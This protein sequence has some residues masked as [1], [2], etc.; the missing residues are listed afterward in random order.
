MK[1]LLLVTSLFILPLSTGCQDSP[2]SRKANQEAQ[3]E[4]NEATRA[5]GDAV[6]VQKREYRK[7]M[8]SELERIDS[9]MKVWKVKMQD[10]TGDAKA[11]MQE[12]LDQL[13][14]KRKK[15]AERLEDTAEDSKAAWA[16]VKQGLD[17]AFNELSDA[18][19]K[20]KEQFK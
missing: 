5:T 8:E 4:I 16:D 18:F 10:A 2:E 20:A 6:A 15:A 13:E 11:S 17:R 12:R 3:R 7:K 1:Q 14:V 9:Q 19:G